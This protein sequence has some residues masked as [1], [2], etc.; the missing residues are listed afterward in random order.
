MSIGYSPDKDP[1]LIAFE[2]DLARRNR[3]AKIAT[4]LLVLVGA[5]L[6]FLLVNMGFSALADTVAR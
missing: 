2:K 6:I 3:T 5:S 4:A 1:D